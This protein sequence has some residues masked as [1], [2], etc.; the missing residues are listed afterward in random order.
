MA[1]ASERDHDRYVTNS[2]G[3]SRSGGSFSWRG[4][5][6]CS[7]P[8]D[9]LVLPHSHGGAPVR[10]RS[11]SGECASSR[12]APAR[13]REQH[14]VARDPGGSR[15]S[16]YCTGSLSLT[17]EATISVGARSAWRPRRAPRPASGARAPRL[18]RTRK[19]HG[20]GDVVIGRP[21]RQLEELV[22]RRPLDRL[23]ARTPCACAGCGLPRRLPLAAKLAN[24]VPPAW[25]QG[26]S[27]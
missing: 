17:T 25:P 6:R 9:V 27:S 7:R 19:R 2:P 14:D 24:R 12:R 8:E 4:R 16:S 5:P 15:S 26:R 13:A 21:A 10:R 23:A 11:T 3:G 22:E 1:R 18:P 20:V